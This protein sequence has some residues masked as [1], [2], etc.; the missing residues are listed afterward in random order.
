MAQAPETQ[1]K[2]ALLEKAWPVYFLLSAVEGLVNVASLFRL[3]ADPKNAFLFGYSASRLGCIFILLFFSLAALWFAQASW[4][5]AA[6]RA[7]WLNPLSSRE[8][9]YWT[10]I[11]LS[12]LIMAGAWLFLVITQAYPKGAWLPIQERLMPVISFFILTCGELV[13][14]ITILRCG[15][16]TRWLAAEQPLLVTSLIV[17]AIIAAGWIF[18]ALTGYGI[19]SD[20]MGWGRRGVPLLSWQ[21]AFVWLLCLLFMVLSLRFKTQQQQRKPSW[22]IRHLDWLIAVGLWACAAGLWMSQPT[23]LYSKNY[24]PN[25][26]SYPSRDSAFY[27][28]VA[29]SILSGNGFLHNEVVP[30]PLYI[31]SIAAFHMVVGNSYSGIILLQTLILALFPVVL[32]L[33]GKAIHSRLA[34]VFIALLG[35]FREL[36]AIQATQ[37]GYVSNSK[38]I[39]SDFPSAL[40]I[41]FLVLLL[42][43]WLQDPPRR[44]LYPLLVGGMLGATILVRSQAALFGP[45]IVF[46]AWL[47]YKKNWKRW[48]LD[49]ILVTLGVMIVIS[50]W[51][52]RSWKLTGA[53]LF[54]RPRQVAM[55]SQ[56]YTI[57][58]QELDLPPA[59]GESD[60][61][62]TARLSQD[63]R[64]FAIQHP[65]LVLN[66]MTDHFT[67]NL[68]DSVLVVPI[69][70]N[71]DDYRD[72]WLPVT[73]FWQDWG[74]KLNAGSGLLLSLN[75]V[76]I[77][78]GIAYAWRKMRWN[79]LS[80]LVI[81]LVYDLSNAMAR[82]SGHRFILPVD[83]I[84]Y[85]YYGLGA[86]QLLI[87]LGA[88]LN[89]ATLLAPSMATSGE[90][91]GWSEKQA[92]PWRKALIWGAVFLGVGLSVNLAEIVFP[93][94]YPTQDNRG[95]IEAI[96]QSADEKA[97]GLDSTTLTNFLSQPG[98]VALWGRGL[99]PY[100][101]DPGV[102]TIDYPSMEAR[103][104]E[105]LG[106]ELIVPSYYS[107]SLRMPNSPG[108][109]PNASDVIVIGCEGK[110]NYVDAIVVLVMG[111]KQAL[112]TSPVPILWK[113]PQPVQP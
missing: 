82:N 39:M 112:Y 29:Q 48:L 46:F 54:D 104:F 102:R 44:R 22:W 53:L 24:L 93:T 6:W 14:F 28:L 3:P 55:I 62:Y 1:L 99:F 33:I 105:R 49:G 101:Y 37:F 30:R 27:E 107:I 36:T 59:P 2:V 50:P 106:F 10:A 71:L 57:T 86:V 18:V 16:S 78:L 7:R 88:L 5:N 108:Y 74:I 40:A 97:A 19:V 41:A 9:I 111:D 61:A 64:S 47:V 21:V 35:I 109:F 12:L 67:K 84:L 87:Y 56:R 11:A 90:Q 80:P 23:Y 34:G 70:F 77:G 95:I 69:N 32:Y 91:A 8:K 38:Q 4:K 103:N 15:I 68:I 58:Q 17:W 73:P 94:R 66:F 98:A 20:S 42:I 113:C 65:G 96:T 72:N 79:G 63:I 26:E 51:L 75:L 83:W 13:I 25:H 43:H 31:L 89:H 85:F 52:W 92:F 60:A 45:F 76:L 100:M 110:D 81:Y